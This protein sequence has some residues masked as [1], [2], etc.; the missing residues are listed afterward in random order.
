MTYRD[1]E[2]SEYLGQPL[3]AIK[4]YSDYNIYTYTPNDEDILFQGRTHQAVPMN[5]SNFEQT[6]EIN[7]NDILISRVPL[8]LDI[9]EL[10]RASPPNYVINILI[11]VFHEGDSES[12]VAWSGTVVNVD[13]RETS[14]N[15]ICESIITTIRKPLLRRNYQI[16]CPHTLYSTGW[17]LCNVDEDDFD[18]TVSNFT[19]SNENRTITHSDFNTLGSTYLTLGYAVFN[20]GSILQYRDIIGHTDGS[21]IIN[22]PFEGLEVTDDITVYPGCNKTM[23]T[24]RDKFNN[25]DNYGGFKYIPKKNPFVNSV[26]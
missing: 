9:V 8:D 25:L 10:F 4:F 16:S 24:C 2:D 13:F 12:I 14:A 17:G 11:S 19:L 15:I 5:L 6:N 18:N 21:I 26:F 20:N 7:K 23:D 22:F 1:R 3:T